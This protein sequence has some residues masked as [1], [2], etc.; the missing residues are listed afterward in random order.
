M[1]KTSIDWT[2]HSW[3]PVHGCS[4]AGPEC[5]RCYAKAMAAR[6]KGSKAKGYENG[7]AVTLRHDRLDEPRRLKKPKMIF[8]CSMGDLFHE[9]VSYTFQSLVFDAMMEADHHVYQV[10]TKRPSRMKEF[11]REWV[12][13][14]FKDPDDWYKVRHIWLGTSVGTKQGVQRALE[15]A[16]VPVRNRFL[17]LE[18]LIEDIDI[19]PILHASTPRTQALWREHTRKTWPGAL[20]VEWVIVGGET[21]SGARILKLEWVMRQKHDCGR[22]QIPFFFKSWGSTV[23]P[24][25]PFSRSDLE[26]L[27]VIPQDIEEHLRREAA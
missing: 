15:L 17:S 7:F 11:V 27:R 19:K 10:L 26:T 14:R 16:E 20:L 23:A 12:K 3:N 8:L 9:R 18:P 5:D 25:D 1:G 13:E 6:L 22:V 21:G 2:H 4:P 24:E